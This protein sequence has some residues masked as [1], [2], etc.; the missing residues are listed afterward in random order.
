MHACR[1]PT[2][3]PPRASPSP[4]ADEVAP[5]SDP[6]PQAQTASRPRQCSRTGRANRV[7]QTHNVGPRLSF[8]TSFGNA[9]GLM[10]ISAPWS[11]TEGPQ[12]A[13]SGPDVFVHSA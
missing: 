5:N 4:C 9:T 13:L 11:Q 10:S 1:S 7:S 2:V 12:G 3:R 8:P 6:H